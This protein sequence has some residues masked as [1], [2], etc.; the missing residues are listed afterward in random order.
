MTTKF[1]K[2]ETAL[3]SYARKVRGAE[4]L[5]FYPVQCDCGE[6]VGDYVSNGDVEKLVLCP[7][8]WAKHVTKR[9]ER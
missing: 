3:R 5:R 1:F 7:E 4:P 8:C 9:G 2:S 6:T